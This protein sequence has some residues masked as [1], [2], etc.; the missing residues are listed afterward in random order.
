MDLNVKT[1]RTQ[2]RSLI[3]GALFVFI[4]YF[5]FSAQMLYA[6]DASFML[7]PKEGTYA[8]NESVTV[9]VLVS[10]GGAPIKVLEGTL[11]FDPKE[12]AVTGINTDASV[13]TSWTTIPR[14]DSDHGG[15]IYFGGWMS[16]S[17]P[18]FEAE[19]MTLTLTPLRAGDFSVKWRDGSAI[20]AADG[21]G[22]NIISGFQSGLYEAIPKDNSEIQAATFFEIDDASTS[23]GV[24]LGASTGTASVVIYGDLDQNF[25]HAATS[26]LLRWTLP[27]DVDA[28]RL[29]ID[30]DPVGRGVVAYDSPLAEKKLVN[31][32]SGEWYF[33][34]TY[35]PLLFPEETAHYK[36][37]IDRI[38]PSYLKAT[39]L[40]RPVTS[41]PNI[42]ILVQATDTPSGIRMYRFT[43]DGAEPTT[44]K[45]D[46]THIFHMLGTAGEHRIEI[47]A[48]DQAG[49]F[50]TTSVAV[51]IDYITAPTFALSE[52]ASEGNSVRMKVHTV[53]NGTVTF[54]LK[55][56]GA[57]DITEDFLA[58]GKGQGVW[59]S[60]HKMAFGSY[61][62]TAIVHDV[63]G[64][65]SLPSEEVTFPVG[66][67]LEGVMM[68]HP[69]IPI[70]SLAFTLLMIFSWYAWK[71][72]NKHAGINK[73]IPSAM[74][75]FD[76]YEDLETPDAGD[77]IV[78][79]SKS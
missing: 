36:L 56:P 29:G 26:T 55:R 32:E 78:L 16:T 77:T 76:P 42:A 46:G 51:S 18:L 30:H 9:R 65:V 44:W 31:L 52:E 24:V 62:A 14:A 2:R 67:T 61:I 25:W 33:H 75:S 5:F 63:H 3:G 58:D 54:T 71:R 23:P 10:S 20:I 66:S 21:T 43:Q 47:A 39:L 64:A 4:G 11:E 17:S 22:G 59:K 68:R 53:P 48:I 45:D 1:F 70:V 15:E 74:S 41:D 13:L 49:N 73:A 8:V 57:E 69:L 35:T 60:K 6:A 79:R 37:S 72:F 28:V 38:A 19:I 7:S 27:P 50:A 12:V 40:D 34:L